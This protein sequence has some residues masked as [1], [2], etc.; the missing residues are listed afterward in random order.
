MNTTKSNPNNKDLNAKIGI[1]D[2]E[3]KRR[4]TKVKNE[5]KKRIKIYVVTMPLF[6]ISKLSKYLNIAKIIMNMH[7]AMI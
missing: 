4:K 1:R 5:I 3:V 6:S 2:P 7:C